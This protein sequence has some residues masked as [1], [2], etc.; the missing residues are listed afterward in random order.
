MGDFLAFSPQVSSASSLLSQLQE[1]TTY[2]KNMYV[3]IRP[4]KHKVPILH[5]SQSLVIFFSLQITG[6]Y[7]LN[8]HLYCCS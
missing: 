5:V 6:N 2:K 8:T 4:C 7:K 1:K 3:L